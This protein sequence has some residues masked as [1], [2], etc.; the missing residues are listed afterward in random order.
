MGSS[1]VKE[2][3]ANISPLMWLTEFGLKIT[4]KQRYPVASAASF[5]VNIG[6]ACLWNRLLSSFLG[7][8]EF[9]ILSICCNI[10]VATALPVYCPGTQI[11]FRS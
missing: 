11:V 8:A 2:E 9:V 6:L 3:L 7:E 10:S 5:G 4:T 1:G